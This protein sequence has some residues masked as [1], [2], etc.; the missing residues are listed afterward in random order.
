MREIRLIKEAILKLNLDLEGLTVFTEAASGH[1]KWTPIIAALAG[2]RKVYAIAKDSKYG[3]RAGIKKE[4]DRIALRLNCANK[5]KIVYDK[6]DIPK[7]DIIT[8]LG[9]VR[10]INK[11]TV[12]KLKPTAVIPLMRETWEFRSTDLNL[13]E[14]RRRN[15]LVI[16]TNENNK[17]I[18]ILD[19]LGPLSLKLLL[20]QGIE[21][22]NS[23]ILILGDDIF[24]DKIKKYLIPFSKKIIHVRNLNE[25][26]HFR[27]LDAIIISERT[28]KECLIG[29]PAEITFKHISKCNPHITIIHI[30]G[31]INTRELL[32]SHLNH[33]PESISPVGFMSANLDFVGPKPVIDLH[34]AGLKVGEIAA[35]MRLKNISINKIKKKL[36]KICLAQI[37]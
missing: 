9:H 22:I 2:S 28:R 12:A 30:C 27:E 37:M 10:P 26:M 34:T 29:L 23:Y 31:N 5:L 7:A 25:N 8:N 16:G 11:T 6:K 13:T 32:D 4:I 24:S 21:L 36:S 14:C 35:R 18:K 15:I 20:S 3:K 33:Y 1:Y 17:K 19:Y